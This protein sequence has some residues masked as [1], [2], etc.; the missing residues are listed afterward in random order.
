MGG[1]LGKIFI[2]KFNAHPPYPQRDPRL[3]EAMGV[4]Q[5]VVSDLVDANAGGA[6][7]TSGPTSIAAPA[8]AVG[9]LLVSGIFAALAIVAKLNLNAAGD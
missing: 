4:S 3:L 9:F 7:M 1:L 8:A 6:E 2:A 5:N